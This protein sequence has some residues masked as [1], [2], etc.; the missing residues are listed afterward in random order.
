MPAPPGFDEIQ[1]R[2]LSRLFGRM[3][4]IR[5]VVIPLALALVLVL[6]LFD[7]ARWR[8]SFLV[9]AVVPL[10]AYFIAEAVRFR[11]RGFRPG[12]VVPNLVGALLGQVALC[13]ATG[14]LESPVT[15]AFVPLAFLAGVFGGRAHWPIIA[16]QVAAVW[17]LA[18]AEL[19]AVVPDLN[20]AAFG[21]GARAGH[22][23]AHLL[24]TAAVLSAVLLLGS[25]VGLAVRRGFDRMLAE[26]LRA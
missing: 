23:T 15:Y 14:A 16:A 2:E 8:A 20:L 6:A 19:T 1:R 5:L 22:T 12:A 4:G 18:A 21:G 7:P 11:R 26:A 25:R 17:G 9:A 10:G 24:T 3:V 13:A